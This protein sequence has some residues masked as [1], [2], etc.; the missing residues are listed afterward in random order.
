M[1]HF[2]TFKMMP[3]HFPSRYTCIKAI[4]KNVFI[5]LNVLYIEEY[6]YVSIFIFPSVMSCCLPYNIFLLIV[7]SV[8]KLYN[9]HNLENVRDLGEDAYSQMIQQNITII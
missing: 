6:T 7:A 3:Q 1:R 2:I 9:V 4:T 5:F 8:S